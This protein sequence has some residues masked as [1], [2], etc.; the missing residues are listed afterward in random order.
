MSSQEDMYDDALLIFFVE[1]R[2]MVQQIE[3]ALFTL[4]HDAGNN[5]TVNALFRAAHTIKGSAGIFSLDRVVDFTHHIES[6]LDRVRTSDLKIDVGLSDVLFKSCD[7]IG[8]LLL[9]AENRN[10]Q[11][12]TL[13]QLDQDADAIAAQLNSY[14]VATLGHDTGTVAAAAS[15]A[16]TDAIIAGSAGSAGI[17]HVSLRFGEEAF[18]HGFD[19][20]AIIHYL[21]SIGDIVTIVTI[22]DGLPEWDR[23]DPETC[24][25]GFEIRLQTVAG[26]AEID[27]A[28]EFV[29]D[30]CTIRLIAPNRPVSDFIA[31]MQDL[32]HEKRLGDILVDCGALSRHALDEALREQQQAEESAL[33]DLIPAVGDILVTQHKVTPEVV[34]AALVQQSKSREP[35][36]D[37]TRFVRVP[38]DK[39]D[40]LIN[41]VG[42]L[43]ICGSSASLQAINTGN[44]NLIGTTQQMSGL[45]EEIRHGALSLRMVQIG[46]TFARYRR[47]VRDV[48]GELGKEVLLEIEG[49]DTELDKSVVEKIG[50]PLMHLVRNAL[51][52]GIETPHAR[53]AA[54]KPA[55]GTIRLSA[56]HDSGH[57]VIRVSDDGRGLD[58]DILQAKARERGLVAPGQIL[59][60][61]EQFNLIFTPGFST[62]EK[63]TNLSGRGVGM[64]VVKKN[65]EALRGTVN[66]QSRPGQGTAVEIRLP[67]TLAI[68]DGFLVKIGASSFVIPLHAVIECI[69]ANESRLHLK[70]GSSGH[71]DLRGG[72]L[73]V[74]DLR[75]VFSEIGQRSGKRSIVVVQSGNGSAG[76]LVD[77]LLGEYQTV[78]KPLGKLFQHLRGISGSTVLGSGEVALI[79][80]VN[81]L[82][83][84]ATEQRHEAAAGS[85]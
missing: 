30:D 7:M 54:G 57:I 78:I 73:P 53:Q 83:K 22:D 32:P 28:F 50:D 36:A 6:V 60:E 82:V 23:L 74:L 71:I 52:H 9:Q 34:D 49:A 69:D 1:A 10:E 62:A 81:A 5:E 14:L 40:D 27:A 13:A 11:P 63:V 59:T 17:W 55:A 45:V 43:V 51:D 58:G 48:A 47:V 26:K 67:L 79:L 37:E 16:A 72:V 3:Q 65:I 56:Q 33:H 84:L 4:E 85:S 38:A 70:H 77:Q 18:R 76:M 64:D 80:D 8:A 61:E 19:P 20:L 31:L 2:E 12:A 66:L 24:H 75:S 41:L 42:E 29:R 15:D 68:I 39:L 21:Q 35:R 44:A 46:E 25:L